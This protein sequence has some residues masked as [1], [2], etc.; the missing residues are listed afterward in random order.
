M[1]E[2]R[3]DIVNTCVWANPTDLKSLKIEP[4]TQRK[5]PDILR[6]AA[7]GVYLGRPMKL[8]EPTEIKGLHLPNRFIRSATWE[9]LADGDGACTPE[10]VDLMLNLSK[11]V[12]A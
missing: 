7:S 10:L 12:L 1:I 5:A 9:G 8:L 11:G 3:G 2:N 4:I 6:K